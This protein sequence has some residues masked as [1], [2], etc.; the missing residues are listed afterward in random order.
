MAITKDSVYEEEYNCLTSD[1]VT[2]FPPSTTGYTDGSIMYALDSST[3]KL[4][5]IFKLVNGVW[6]LFYEV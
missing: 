5:K 3:K 4:V 2:D 6:Y 1:L